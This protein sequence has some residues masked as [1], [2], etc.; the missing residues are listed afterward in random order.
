MDA[1]AA[2]IAFARAPVP[3]RTKT[4][5]I[6]ALGPEG[7]AELYRCFL[8]D[9]LEALGDVPAEIIVAAAAPEDVEALSASLS[10]HQ[11][12]AEVIVQSGADLG[13]RIAN[14]VRHA[15]AQGH[16]AAV[17]I[18]T[19]APD[20]PPRV[21]GRALQLIASHDLVLGPCVDGGYYLIGLR[22]VVPSL[23]RDIDWSTDTVLSDTIKRAS[24]LGLTVAL[25]EPWE[26]VDT[27]GD[28]LRLRERL[29]RRVLAGEPIPCRR[30]WDC[31]CDLPEGEG[32]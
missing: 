31:L 1:R 15:L 13:E 16:C 11:V 7:A 12:G 14:A 8:L 2:V 22:A 18:G 30:T 23:L 5:L 27:P 19:D 6:P 9:T 3:G 28:L 20:L 29:A 21:I 4:R 17:V 25:L 32:A 10:A 24:D 26:D